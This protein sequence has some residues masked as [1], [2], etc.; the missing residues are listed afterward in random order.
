M[1]WRVTRFVVGARHR[2]GQDQQRGENAQRRGAPLRTHQPFESRSDQEQEEW[3]QEQD[4]SVAE[5]VD[6][7]G[8]GRKRRGNRSDD[9]ECALQT[10]AC[11][12][13]DTEQTRDDRERGRCSGKPD[14]IREGMPKVAERVDQSVESLG[15]ILTRCE[16]AALATRR[17]LSWFTR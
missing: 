16:T 2:V 12:G 3:D 5:R 11:E 15:R 1:P 7:E 8:R 6:V 10:D 9:Q 4:E 13:D 14:R 17:A